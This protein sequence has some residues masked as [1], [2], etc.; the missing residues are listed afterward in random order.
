M[1]LIPDLAAQLKANNKDLVVVYFSTASKEGLPNITAFP[2]SDVVES[3]GNDLI[4]LP[5]LFLIKTKINLNENRKAVISFAAGTNQPEYILEGVADIIQWGHPGS[6]KLFGL[7]SKDVLD[8][9]GDWDGNIE[10]VIAAENEFIRP[11]VYAQRG[12]VVFKPNNIRKVQ[13]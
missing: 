10:P 8:K 9:W 5:D 7:K 2:F 1:K 12:V 13:E 3:E 11:S 6:F 4:L